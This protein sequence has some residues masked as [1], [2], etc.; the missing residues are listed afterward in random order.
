MLFDLGVSSMQ[1]DHAGRGF[2]YAQDAPLDMRM[3]QSTGVTAADVLNTYPVAEL[4]RIL[5]EYGEERFA[6]RVA[7]AIGRERDASPAGLDGTSGRHRPRRDP[8]GDPPDRRPPGQADV[9]GA[10][11]RGQR[12]T[13]GTRAAIPAATTAL[14]VGGRIVVL[15]YH[16][17]EDRLVKQHLAALA[18]DTT[19]D[20]LPVT[21]V[22]RRPAVA[23]ADPGRISRRRRDRRELPRDV[24]A[25]TCG[26]AGPDAG[27]MAR[28][29]RSGPA[30][31]G[32]PRRLPFGLLLAGLVVGGLCALLALN[33]AAAADEVRGHELA[34]ANETLTGQVE[35]LHSQVAAAQAPAA[36]AAAAARLGM[37]PVLNPAFLV[38][39]PDGKVQVTGSA[40]PVAGVAT[41]TPTPTPPGVTPTP[42]DGA[43]PTPTPN[44]APG[45]PM[46]GGTPTPRP[47]ADAEPGRPGGPG[48]QRAVAGR[49]AADRWG[50]PVSTA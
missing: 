24:G 22:R 27:M 25:A 42:V 32:R 48:R 31:P 18:R 41:P 17:L 15:S 4:A 12:R 20:G 21:A 7:Q 5:R 13:G 47:R 45:A 39:G 50:G 26:R 35:Q 6:L 2:A 38:V 16:S 46:P 40:S 23:F 19:P 44:P 34:V 8:G 11:H 29:S 49:P 10:A 33:T 43:A 9:P 36:L 14:G 1:L 28:A 3:D 30:A 37:A